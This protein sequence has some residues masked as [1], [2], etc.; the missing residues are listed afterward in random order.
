MTATAHAF[1]G[2]IIAA[3]IANPFIAVP[4]AI[5]SHVIGDLIPHWDS[6]THELTK[7]KRRVT[8]EAVIDVLAGFTLPFVMLSIVFPET[9]YIYAFFMIIMAQFFDWT[10]APYYFFNIKYPPFTWSY[11]LSKN[12]FDNRLDK[13]WGIVTQVTAVL[14]LLFAAKYV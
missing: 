1:I 3:K 8:I 4:V 14:L 11:Y 10:T 2:A 13:P 7:S 6:G 5:A 9:N 12:Y